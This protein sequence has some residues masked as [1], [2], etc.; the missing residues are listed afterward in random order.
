MSTRCVYVKL[1]SLLSL[2]RVTSDFCLA[3]LLSFRQ[4]TSDFSLVILSSFRQVTSDCSLV[5]S[6]SLP[7]HQD[8]AN[9]G[10]LIAEIQEVYVL[11]E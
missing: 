6:D 4:V 9:F 8:L 5:V 7:F 3:V 2:N 11:V 1:T 10:I